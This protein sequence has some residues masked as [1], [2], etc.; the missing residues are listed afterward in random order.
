M[1]M[2]GVTPVYGYTVLRSEDKQTMVQIFWDLET[3]MHPA[4]AVGS[5]GAANR[6]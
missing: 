4:T 2:V 5:V 6:S 3:G 1:P